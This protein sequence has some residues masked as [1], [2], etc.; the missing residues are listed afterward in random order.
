[1]A[2][3]EPA[4]YA[5]VVAPAVFPAH[6]MAAAM[7]GSPVLQAAIPYPAAMPVLAGGHEHSGKGN[8]K[9]WAGIVVA[10]VLAGSYF[11]SL[12]KA[13]PAPATAPAQPGAQPAAPAQPG[14]ATAPAA[15]AQPNAPAQPGF[16]APS[17]APNQPG[18]SVPGPANMAV[19]QQSFSGQWKAI[20]GAVEVTNSSW[21]N[22]S[23]VAM[24][25][26][27][28]QCDQFSA[29]GADLSQMRMTLNGPVP[30][31]GTTNFNPFQMGAVNPMMSKVNCAI[32]DVNPVN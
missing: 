5:P 11:S 25:Q 2:A 23:S 28:L 17:G 8:G 26:A 22:H 3:P 20:Y 1:V 7:P 32:V 6:A 24:Q 30:A 14:V 13:A 27:I 31:G 15:P 21:T 18:I 12:Q 9:V 29:A 4:A 10:V 16:P 19:L